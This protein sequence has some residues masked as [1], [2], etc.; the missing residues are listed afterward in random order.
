MKPGQHIVRLA[1]V[2]IAMII[3]Y[4]LPSVAW[5]HGGHDYHHPA[6]A[7]TQAAPDVAATPAPRSQTAETIPSSAGSAI[8]TEAAAFPFAAAWQGAA[9]LALN[10]SVKANDG[11]KGCGPGACQGS[12]CGPMTCCVT[13][14]L[15]GSA[16]LPA[17]AF[18]HVRMVPNDVAV[19]SGLGPEALPEPPRPLA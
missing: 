9:S 1:A 3:A 6:V 19:V 15:T 7:E 16:S 14:I 18:G 17:R 5:A 12:C 2:M 11:G 10:G 13:G 4:A 8:A